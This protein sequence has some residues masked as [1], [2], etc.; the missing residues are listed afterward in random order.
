MLVFFKGAE[1]LHSGPSPSTASGLNHL[2]ISTAP[3][4]CGSSIVRAMVVTD[5]SITMNTTMVRCH[6]PR[7]SGKQLLGG[8][9]KSCNAET[10]G[11]KALQYIY[12]C[13]NCTIDS[14]NEI[15]PL[16]ND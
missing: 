4:N 7:G 3:I 12:Q 13:P 1:Y 15:E 9:I 11:H 16:K 10:T 8:H 5:D 6:D 2:A 14:V